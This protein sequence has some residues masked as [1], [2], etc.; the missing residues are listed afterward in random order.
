[1]I[2]FFLNNLQIYKVFGIIEE[3]FEEMF[4][5]TLMKKEFGQEERW[6][7]LAKKGKQ[8]FSCDGNEWAET[9]GIKREVDVCHNAKRLSKSNV[10]QSEAKT[11]CW[12]KGEKSRVHKVGVTEILRYALDDKMIGNFYYDT[13]S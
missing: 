10:I 5:F 13:P 9:S 12:A 2:I 4:A 1:M 3:S 7:S 6:S 8:G 11:S